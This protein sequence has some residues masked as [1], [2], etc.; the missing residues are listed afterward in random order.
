MGCLHGQEIICEGKFV[1]RLNNGGSLNE[2]RSNSMEGQGKIGVGDINTEDLYRFILV[3]DDS[4]SENMWRLDVSRLVNLSTRRQGSLLNG[5]DEKKIDASAA[6]Q[7]MHTETMKT[8]IITL[9][10]IIGLGN[11]S[12]ITWK[13]ED[14]DTTLGPDVGVLINNA[15]NNGNDD[16]K[17]Q[18]LYNATKFSLLV[19]K[20]YTQFCNDIGPTKLTLDNFEVQVLRH[21]EAADEE[22]TITIIG[23]EIVQPT[24]SKGMENNTSYAQN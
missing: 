22:R 23:M 10:K 16:T 20:L 9:Q 12:E 8:E 18:H 6:V 15:I 11:L 1:C 19:A 14:S 17:L 3:A 2:E 5:G 13:L 21:N 24:I 4:Y 7:Q